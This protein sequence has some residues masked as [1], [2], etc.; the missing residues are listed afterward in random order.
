M[1]RWSDGERRQWYE[2]LP[3]FLGSA[4]MLF[5]DADDRVLLV[6]PN[7]R[8]HWSLPGGIVEA[9]ERPDECAEREIAEEL[10]LQIQAGQ[11]LV[12]DWMLA[13]QPRPHAMANFLFDGGTITDPAIIKLQADELDDFI[14]APA[15]EA[16]KYLPANIAPRIPAGLQARSGRV[17]IY[18]PQAGSLRPI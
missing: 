18:L 5:T 12:V 11:L 15:S 16:A 6:K 2:S 3:R 7:Y 14:F 1:N 13:E 17:P 9:D 4:G 10:G 8:D